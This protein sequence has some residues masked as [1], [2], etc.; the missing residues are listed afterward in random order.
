MSVLDDYLTKVEPQQR[1][2]LERIRSIVKEMLPDAEE[3]ISY[4]MPTLMYRGQPILGFDA[5][6]NHIG[7]YPYSG[8]VISKIKELNKYDKTKGAIREDL[9]NPLP[10]LLIQKMVTERLKQLGLAD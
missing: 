2:E 6:K 3:V 9:N 5:H 7:I 8:R 1:R 4:A 10:K